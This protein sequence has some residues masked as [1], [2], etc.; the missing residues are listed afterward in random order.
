MSEIKLELTPRSRFD[1]INV[2][3]QVAEQFGDDPLRAYR[4]AI[5]CSY[6][7]TAGYLEENLCARLG[8][9]REAI[10][11]Y[12]ASFQ[13]LFP[14]NGPY[15]HDQMELRDELSDEQKTCEPLN[16]DSHLTFM[17]AGLENCVTYRKDPNT[18]VY[19][20]DLDGVHVGG[21]RTRQT[22]IIGYNTDEQVTE[23]E[24]AIPVSHQA[25]DSINLRDPK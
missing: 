5:Y 21:T 14:P 19:F 13:H 12:C 9:S 6:H 22:T 20:I 10:E 24:F 4:K 15:R 18:P 8:H 17:G 25:V 23:V 2:A 11:A 1:L 3:D 16:A 7:T